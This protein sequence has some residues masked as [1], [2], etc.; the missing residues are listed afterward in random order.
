[1]P[2]YLYKCYKGGKLMSLSLLICQPAVAPG[3]G[4]ISWYDDH[5][6]SWLS[7]H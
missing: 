7:P 5:C 2:G 3:N 1:M 6:S 4:K